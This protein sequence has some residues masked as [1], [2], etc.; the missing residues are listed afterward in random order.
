MI[1]EL[2]DKTYQQGETITAFGITVTD[3]DQDTVTVTVTGLPSG[4][5]YANG[6]V[7]G[8]VAADA[9][10][11]AY[12]ATISADDGVN[13]AVTETFTVTVTEPASNDLAPFF[14]VAISALYFNQGED[15]G[16]T[17]LPEAEGGDGE[18]TYSL[19]PA[20]PEGLSY[21]ADTRTLSGTPTTAGE[22]AMTYTATDEDGDEAAF[23]FT[24]TVDPPPPTAKF[25]LN[26]VPGT[27][28][29]TRI[30]YNEPTKPGLRVSWTA[31][32]MKEGLAR[33]EVR[34][35]K[36]G[37]TS[38]TTYGVF[39]PGVTSFD[40]KNLEAGATYHVQ[41]RARFEGQVGN[42]AVRF[43]SNWSGTGSGRANSPPKVVGAW[44][45]MQGEVG[46]TR[47]YDFA[48]NKFSDADGDTLHYWVNS[49]YPGVV[50]AWV[51][52]DR[53]SSSSS[54]STP[55]GH[56]LPMGRTIPTAAMPTRRSTTPANSLRGGKSS[57]L[58]TRARR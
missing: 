46:T 52:G 55:P 11:Q 3:A 1:T 50:E 36:E 27:P 39:G 4:L 25:V 20:P 9:A 5:S 29:V 58:P 57:R 23:T 35:R 7:S 51:E 19:T 44:L 2:G 8:T 47:H 15:A 37:Q 45:H 41:V 26:P 53:R 13:A 18:L 34:Y 24:I 42:K 43:W 10:A 40:W 17:V 38:I 21:A 12:T 33:Y 16:Q 6:Q 30:R 48:D 54:S 28:T 22:Y 31:P 49:S 32:E 14:S 56:R